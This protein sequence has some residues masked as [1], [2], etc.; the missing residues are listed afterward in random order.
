MR[1]KQSKP[2]H[3]NLAAQSGLIAAYLGMPSSFSAGQWQRSCGTTDCPAAPAPCW[4]EEA[5][6]QPPAPLRSLQ[7]LTAS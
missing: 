4:S 2:R 1:G 3:T 6:E 7:G 5:D